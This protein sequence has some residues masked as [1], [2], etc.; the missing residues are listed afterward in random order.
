MSN[1]IDT[2]INTE[3]RK[4]TGFQMLGSIL[5]SLQ[6]LIITVRKNFFHSIMTT[7]MLLSLIVVWSAR[8]NI[9][10]FLERNPSPAQEKLRFDQTILAD[11]QINATL[12][13]I[14]VEINADRVLIRQFH[15]SKTDLTGLPFA[16]VSTTYYATGAGIALDPISFSAYPLSSVNEALALMHPQDGRPICAPLA[17]NTV[18]DP[19]YRILLETNGVAISYNCP[20]VNLRGQP[21]GFIIASYLTDNKKRPADEII[22]NTLDTTGVKV[23]GYLHSVIHQEKTPWYSAIFPKE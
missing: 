22:M 13:A 2:P 8:G 23:V 19:A 9:S 10:T 3:T 6:S 14:R 11:G 12:E 17:T 16:S 21:V 18:S 1:K 15:N 20:I 4:T 5:V 7:L